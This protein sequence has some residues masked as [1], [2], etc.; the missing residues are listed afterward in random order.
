MGIAISTEPSAALAEYATVPIAYHVIEVF[1]IVTRSGR[2]VAHTLTARR[3]AGPVLKDYDAEPGNSPLDWPKRFDLSTWGFLAA[4]EAGQRVGGAVVVHRSQG[5][6]LLE[7]RDDLAVLWDI[8]VAPDARG[9][10]VGSALLGAA[11]RWAR[12]RGARVLK[13]ETQNT[14]APACRFYARHGFDLRVVNRG[15]YPTLPDEIQLF[16]YK[17]LG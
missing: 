17:D 11:E 15:A 6:E 7:G 4:H 5:I 10:G 9:R 13:V 1:D 8:R 14:N 16:W 3:L 12:E 2:D